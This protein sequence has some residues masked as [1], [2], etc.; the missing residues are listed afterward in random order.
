MQNKS[1]NVSYP[2]DL[3]IA[4]CWAR[5]NSP[6]RE[7][8]RACRSAVMYSLSTL[9]LFSALVEDIKLTWLSCRSGQ[10]SFSFSKALFLTSDLQLSS[11]RSQRLQTNRAALGLNECNVLLPLL[12]SRKVFKNRT[13][14]TIRMRECQFTITRKPGNPDCTIINEIVRIKEA[15]VC[16]TV[17]FIEH[18]RP[19]L[20]GFRIN[21]VSLYIR[22]CVL[23]KRTRYLFG[24]RQFF[25]ASP[26]KKPQAHYFLIKFDVFLSLSVE[27]WTFKFCVFGL[28]F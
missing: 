24:P 4:S 6:L 10:M 26:V 16:G 1:I 8:R 11:I 20:R 28:S 18:E 7:V 27:A 25:G 14:C 13:S 15:C 22:K 23:G 2:Y 9:R 12:C 21:G 5:W 3:F 19:D 17:T